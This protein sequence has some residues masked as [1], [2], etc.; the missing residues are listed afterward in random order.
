MFRSLVIFSSLFSMASL[1]G[2]F[3]V[4]LRLLNKFSISTVF[5]VSTFSISIRAM[6][7]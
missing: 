1:A 7:T 4:S 3:L 5:T 2:Y 6:I